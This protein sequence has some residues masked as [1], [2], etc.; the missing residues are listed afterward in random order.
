MAS[1]QPNFQ[2]T[3]R[4]PLL[5]RHSM[6]YHFV[7]DPNTGLTARWGSAAHL[8]P[9][10]APWPELVD[11]SIS[12]R[13]SKGCDFCYRDSTPS[14][15]LMSLE[16]YTF[17]LEQLTSPQWGPPF[18]VALGGGEPLEHPQ[19]LD[20]LDV[21]H[22]KGIIA[23]FTTN[24]E[25]LT[26]ALA[27]QLSGKVSALALSAMGLSEFHPQRVTLLTQQGIRTNL[28][29]ILDEYTLSEAIAIA[30]GQYDDLLSGLSSIVFLTRKPQGRSNADGI[31]TFGSDRLTR[32]LDA[33]ATH[34]SHLA[35]GFDACA[36]PLLLHHGQIDPQ[37]VDACECGFFSVYV[38]EK[39]EVR[40]CSFAN[41][42]QYGWDLN[43]FSFAEIWTTKFAEY[44]KQQ[45]S[46][47]CS[48]TCVGKMHCRGKC[49]LFDEIAFC[50][51]PT[52][53]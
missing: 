16:Q 47:T 38:D 1:I 30:E 15:A 10:Q 40:P 20:I 53:K 3:S 11:I 14:G 12:N 41:K 31:L 36:V 2:P 8:D 18:Q 27:K 9:L 21:T 39:L 5:R 25:Q 19:L 51:V 4:L 50:F 6:G 48:R 46:L 37:T 52:E 29:Y 24:G 23:N 35:L 45:L 13:C 49:P 44:R 22:A 32:F 28:H 42:G 34:Q 17:L 7:G 33:V 43:Q 26:A